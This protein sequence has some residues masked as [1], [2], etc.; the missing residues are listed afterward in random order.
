MNVIR[1]DTPEIKKLVEHRMSVCVGCEFLKDGGMLKAKCTKCG[2]PIIAKA[3]SKRSK[4][5][6]QKWLM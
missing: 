2:C 6:L 1:D 3:R 4:C 5:P